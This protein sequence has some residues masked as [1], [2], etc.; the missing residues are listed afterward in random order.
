MESLKMKIRHIARRLAEEELMKKHHHRGG[1]S[2]F[3]EGE[4]EGEA[5]HKRRH[6]TRAHKP[7]G[8]ALIDTYGLDVEGGKRRVGRPRKAR[9]GIIAYG[10][11]DMGCGERMHRGKKHHMSRGRAL[12]DNYGLETVSGGRRT[13]HKEGKEYVKRTRKP[14]AYNMFVKEYIL[15]HKGSNIADAA[16]SWRARK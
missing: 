6:M 2:A 5:M 9:A 7:R 1:I 3:G 13:Y 8:M 12:D 11:D 4:G 16:A 14:S 15:K 10:M